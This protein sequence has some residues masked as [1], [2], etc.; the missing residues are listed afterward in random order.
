MQVKFHK[1]FV[2]KLN[3]LSPK[4]Q[5]IFYIKLEM[6]LKNK[7][8]NSLNNHKLKGVYK[9]K[10]SIDILGDLRAIFEERDNK[11]IFVLIGTHSELY[12]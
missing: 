11:I 2:K 3:K 5:N 6:F 4:I 9:Y 10:R 12:K 1:K 8:D 7:F